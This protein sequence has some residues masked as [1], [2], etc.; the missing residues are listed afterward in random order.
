MKIGMFDALG[1]RTDRL[2]G[3]Q[4]CPCGGLARPTPAPAHA[5]QSSLLHVFDCSYDE[6][7]AQGGLGSAAH[8]IRIHNVA[9]K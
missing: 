5:W 1:Q 2:A 9:S 3:L 8:I 7:K 6:A 4:N